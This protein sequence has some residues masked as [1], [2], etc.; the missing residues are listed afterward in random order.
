MSYWGSQAQLREAPLL[1]PGAAPSVPIWYIRVPLMLSFGENKMCF[2]FCQQRKTLKSLVWQVTKA[3][4]LHTVFKR[5][6]ILTYYPSVSR[7]YSVFQIHLLKRLKGWKISFRKVNFNRRNH[8]KT[9]QLWY[10]EEKPEPSENY[11]WEPGKDKEKV[12]G[13]VCVSVYINTEISLQNF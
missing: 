2:S 11:L 4:K 1:H 13:D 9:A 10:V 3:V 5:D 8:D 6:N 12:K 7:K